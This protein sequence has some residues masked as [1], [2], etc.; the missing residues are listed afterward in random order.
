[1]LLFFKIF[2]FL[3]N[4]CLF[5]GIWIILVIF[6]FNDVIFIDNE[7]ILIL[8]VCWFGKEIVSEDEFWDIYV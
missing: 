7:D 6:C 3:F 1:M 5:V 2:D 4:L 8:M